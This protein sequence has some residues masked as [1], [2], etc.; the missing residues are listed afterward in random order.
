[1]P[2]VLILLTVLM[3]SNWIFSETLVFL[4]IHL[5]DSLNS[6]LQWGLWLVLLLIIGWCFGEPNN[7]SK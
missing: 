7:Q 5:L 1:M 6:I 4:P 3:I 2:L